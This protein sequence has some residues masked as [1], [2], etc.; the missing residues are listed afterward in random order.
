MKKTFLLFALTCFISVSVTRGQSVKDSKLG[1]GAEFLLPFG[2]NAGLVDYGVGASLQY[3]HTLAEQVRLS[4]SVGYIDFSGKEVFVGVKY[5]EGYVP[6][7]AGLK[8]FISTYIYAAGEGGVAISTANGSGSGTAFAYSAGA[9]TEF[10]V[11]QSNTLDFGLR[12]EGWSR[13]NGTR[14]FAGLRAGFN[15]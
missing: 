8:Y 14:S 3:Q 6:I 13:S 1:I 7:K 10:P 11:G 4:L 2:D 5:D 15:F 12:Y 9:G